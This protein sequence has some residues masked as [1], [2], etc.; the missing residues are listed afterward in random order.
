VSAADLIAWHMGGLHPIETVLVLL[1]AFGPFL[2]IGLVVLLRRRREGSPTPEV[3]ES[4][5]GRDNQPD[6]IGR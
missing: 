4:N 6:A 5:T 3:D 2:I 1:L